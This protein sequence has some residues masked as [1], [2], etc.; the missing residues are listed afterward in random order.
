[1]ARANPL[2]SSVN[3]GEFSPRMEA[4]V[5]FDRYPNAARTCRNLLLYPQGGMTR[6]PGTRFVKE[7]KDSADAT[8]ALPFQF[9]Q[10]EAYVVEIGDAYM[11]F[12]HRQAR[13]DAANITAT[14]TN[15]TF[16]SNINSWSD[17]YNLSTTTFVATTSDTSNASTYTFN[18]ASI[19][20]ASDSRLV[21]VGVTAEDDATGV[22][23]S[24]VTIGGSTAREIVQASADEGA[25]NSV[26]AGLFYLRVTTGTTANIVVTLSASSLRC[27]ISVFRVLTNLSAEYASSS[28]NTISGAG[29]CTT[30]LDVPRDGT[31]LGV[32]CFDSGSAITGITWAGLTEDDD[33]NPE[34]NLRRG[35]AHADVAAGETGRTISATR[36]GGGGTEAGV[37]VC[38]SFGAAS[39]QHDSTNL[40]LQLN[41]LTDYSYAEQSVSITETS[42]AHTLQFRMAGYGGAK[43]DLR[44]GTATGTADVLEVKD[45]D[46]G[47]HTFTFTPGAATVYIGFRQHNAPSRNMWLDNVAF[48]DNAPVEVVSPYATTEL[49][50]LRYFQAADVAY[51]C[52]PDYAIRRLER[53]GDKSWSLVQPFFEDGPYLEANPGTDLDAAQLVLNHDFT[54]G[55]EHWTFDNDSVDANRVAWT[56]A[57]SGM[58]VTRSSGGPALYQDITCQ[59]GATHVAHILMA[60]Q[61]GRTS[62]R[63]GTS[64]N[65]TKWLNQTLQAGWTTVEFTPTASAVRIK[66]E[67]QTDGSYIFQECAIYAKS[68]KLMSASA[69][70][71]EVTLTAHG[72]EPFVASDVGRIVR[73]TWP[74]RE[75]GYGVITAYTS[76]TVV[77]LLVLRKLASTCRTENWAMG[78]WCTAQGFPQVIGFIDGRLVAAATDE[79]P[80]TL[81]FSQTNDLQN[82]RPDSFAAGSVTVEDDDAITATLSSKR[83]D[84]INWISEQERLLVGTAGQEWMIFAGQDAAIAPTNITAKPT[85]FVPALN[86]QAA[87]IAEETFFLDTT[88][89]EVYGLSFSFDANKYVSQLLTIF[90][91]HILKSPGIQVAYQRRPYSTLWVVRSDGRLASLGYNR[92][93]EVLGWTQHILG[94]AFGSG[95]AVVE[96]IAII[97][98]AVDATQVNDSD[99][100]DEVWLVVKRTINGSTKRYLEVME[101]MLEGPYRE[102]YDTEADWWAAVRT[103]QEGGFYV[104]CGITYDSSSTSTI[105]GLDHLEGQSVAVLADGKVQASK[106]VASG[107]ITLDVAASV[108]QAGLAYTLKYESLKLA[109]G[110]AIGTA[111]N[112]VKAITGCGVVVLDCGTFKI[113]TVEYDEESGRR[114]HDLYSIDFSMPA[115]DPT[116]A[117]PLFTGEKDTSL[118][119]TYPTDARIYIESSAPLP[120]TILA[121]A[122]RITGTDET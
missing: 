54:S 45:L 77:T 78:A 120:C 11:R 75:P 24:S 53:R 112:K 87:E 38:A 3:A 20:A 67:A 63:V 9:S 6:R 110:A 1:M 86:V 14:I 41:G 31:A 21:V 89:R 61:D 15:G 96:S 73:L 101:T 62:F 122:P 116:D 49:A 106:T 109:A 33:T 37:M 51:L 91:D 18:S 119:T 8:L 25:G 102:D 23:I 48:I 117:T 46:I 66:L 2:L 69:T 59:S 30:T 105:T 113:T 72:H 114:Q 80:Q 118:E 121:L 93:Q 39:L 56:D 94:G 44:I 74:G 83:V 103:A 55:D 76:T 64:G 50:D 60:G 58:T 10:S 43:F 19:G 32:A 95:D 85:S 27:S 68:A 47:E 115:Q 28:D 26:T 16:G 52:H 108:V 107:Q 79:Q 29:V 71:G 82:M 97:P 57:E 65:A 40:R 17:P 99:E 111:V 92:Q 4:R 70:T 81:W 36:A 88:G 5:D 100:R 98:G 34:G 7:V 22:T 84:P 13:L 12:Y 104:D 42:T 35:A 90:A